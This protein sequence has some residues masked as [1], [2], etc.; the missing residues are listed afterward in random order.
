MLIF[1]SIWRPFPWFCCLWAVNETL[2]VFLFL[3]ILFCSPLVYPQ[4]LGVLLCIAL[5]ISLV[6]M[7]LPDFAFFCFQLSWDA[8]CSFPCFFTQ[9]QPR[10]KMF[11]LD[12]QLVVCSLPFSK[13]KKKKKRKLH[14]EGCQMIHYAASRRGNGGQGVEGRHSGSFHYKASTSVQQM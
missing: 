5:L 1:S 13:K 6:V 11:R 3:L 8:L 2:L 10:N 12:K 9:C 7:T 14:L 4:F